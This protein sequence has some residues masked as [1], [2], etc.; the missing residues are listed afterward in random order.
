[1]MKKS[2]LFIALAFL[3]RVFSADAQTTRWYSYADYAYY[4]S[5]F[6][7]D[8]AEYTALPIWNDTSAKYGY[9][10]SGSPAYAHVGF[11]SVGLSF[12]PRL[13][14]W[15]DVSTYGAT[16]KVGPNDAY[17]I[18]SVRLFGSYLRNNSKLAPKDTIKLAFVYGDG[19]GTTNLQTATLLGTPYGSSVSFLEMTHDSINNIAGKS[20]GSS[21]NPYRQNI[22]LSSTDTATSYVKSFALASSFT[23]PAGNCASMSLTFKSGDASYVPNDTIIYAS[24]THK[25]GAFSPYIQYNVLYTGGAVDYAILNPIDSNVGYFKD[26]K[27][28]PTGW[29]GL[30]IPTWSWTSGGGP[31]ILQTPMID[32]H[33]TCP[34]CD[35]SD[36]IAGTPTVCV[37]ATTPLT[38]GYTGGAWTSGAT[39]KATVSS[40]GVVSGVAAGTA[41][42]TY[43]L[44][45]HKSV[46]TV[47]VLPLPSAGGIVG[48]G[49]LCGTSFGTYTISGG[50]PGG[51][52]TSSNTT[53][54]DA[55][56]GGG[57]VHA[58]GVGAAVLSYTVTNSCGTAYAI[59]SINVYPST[60]GTILGP[61]TVCQG[62]T[63]TLSNIVTSGTWTS[64]ATGVATVDPA[65]G[66]VT[67][68]SGGTASIVY[69]VLDACSTITS[70][71]AAITVQ[72]LPDAGSLSGNN[73]VCVD[74]GIM[75]TPSV[76]GGSWLAENG[77]AVVVLG[78]VVGV[79]AGVDPIYYIVTNSCGNDTVI[80]NVT[81]GDCVNGVDN[82]P[83]LQ[84]ISIYPNPA[85]TKI[86]ITSS[87]VISSVT[88]S[89]MVG[90][91]LVVNKYTDKTVTIG[92]EQLPAGIYMVKV[93]NAKVYKVIKQ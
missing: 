21:I 88:I 48:P 29:S 87:S 22:I 39:A 82:V 51:A 86:T 18:D 81:V 53:V 90:Q 33:I 93:N 60:A 45:G 41:N 23:V 31:S 68:V 11:T 17:T 36:T 67:G 58:V 9:M 89:N 71:S 27:S 52:W 10:V 35:L 70:T 8:N 77:H 7:G 50:S 85:Q 91:E 65:T 26:A 4:Q 76:S 28:S 83:S 73:T 62:A 24:G 40:S 6:Y 57:S 63:I 38:I 5:I 80:Y 1:M 3:F 12:A 56:P 2:T 46:V 92:L 66:V 25:Y 59:R 37:S 32:Y 54:L 14:T 75:L 84:D 16:I 42:I 64:T 44:S 49:A 72:G 15:N 69:S 47:T 20:I 78:V 30:Y 13:S 43:T 19:S 34:T 74:S 79:S 55:S 61:T